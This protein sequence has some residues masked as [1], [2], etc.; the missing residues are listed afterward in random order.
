MHSSLN[1]T[2]VFFL[3][4]VWTSS[5]ISWSEIWQIQMKFSKLYSQYVVLIAS[6]FHGDWP[7]CYKTL[8]G[9]VSVIVYAYRQVCVWKSNGRFFRHKNQLDALIQPAYILVDL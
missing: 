1:A 2:N 8:R 5:L 6:K 4:Q 7:H 3:N 9:K